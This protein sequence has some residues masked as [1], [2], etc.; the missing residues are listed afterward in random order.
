MN[1]HPKKVKTIVINRYLNGESISKISHDMNISRTAVY[2]W[3]KQ[4]NN[5]FNKGKAPNFR[6]LNVWN[7]N[8]KD[9][10]KLL[11]YSS[12]LRVVRTR[13]YQKDM[14]WLKRFL[15]NIT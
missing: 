14:K 6:Y 8:A 4:H 9:N 11:K 10:K 15:L 13:R 2:T 3:V 1:K 7:K 5:S 12:D